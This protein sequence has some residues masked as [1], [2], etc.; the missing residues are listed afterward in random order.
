MFTGLTDLRNLSLAENG[1]DNLQGLSIL[2]TLENL[3]LKQTSLE[4]L[5]QLRPLVD[6]KALRTISFDGSP[7]ATVDAFKSDMILLLPWL[8]TIVEEAISFG[9]RQDEIALDEERKAGAERQRK[10]AEASEKESEAEKE[11]SE[12]DGKSHDDESKSEDATESYATYESD[13]RYNF[14]WEGIFA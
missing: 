3:D 5:K 2:S 14:F 12:A 13:D 9:E 4:K 11:G 10:E 7:V 8:E 1:I 6:F